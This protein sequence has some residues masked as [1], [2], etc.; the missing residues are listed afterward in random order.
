[1]LGSGISREFT[2]AHALSQ[3]GIIAVKTGQAENRKLIVILCYLHCKRK[4]T[5]D[6]RAIQIHLLP[7]G[8]LTT[9]KWE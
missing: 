9:I 6:D 2:S 7:C 4:V 5:Y 8:L 1:L 3:P